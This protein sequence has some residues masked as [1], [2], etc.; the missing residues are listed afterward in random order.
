MATF[1]PQGRDNVKKLILAFEEVDDCFIE[2]VRDAVTARAQIIG[3]PSAAGISETDLQTLEAA[4]SSY[5]ASNYDMD[6]MIQYFRT[7]SSHKK[8]WKSVTSSLLKAYVKTSKTELFEWKIRLKSMQNAGRTA[9]Q[10]AIPCT[11]EFAQLEEER[12]DI[13]N[14]I[15]D[16]FRIFDDFIDQI[17]LDTGE[18]E[19]RARF[20]D[21]FQDTLYVNG[22]PR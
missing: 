18:T 12:L 1:S 7:L 19:K 3:A 11:H 21:E 17:W 14:S 22:G 2:A 6:D 9:W 4:R 20:A 10:V 8:A 16:K 5:H 13:I 15:T